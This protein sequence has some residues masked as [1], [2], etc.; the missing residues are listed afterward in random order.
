MELL[1]ELYSALQSLL[2]NTQVAMDT[3]IDQIYAELV[4]HTKDTVV[5]LSIR[6][7][8][9]WLKKRW[10]YHGETIVMCREHL[11]GRVGVRHP[12]DLPGCMRHTEYA[13]EA[14]E[15]VSDADRVINGYRRM[16]AYNAAVTNK[17]HVMCLW[18]S[19]TSGERARDELVLLWR[20]QVFNST[21]IADDGTLS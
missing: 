3:P 19:L 14:I 12:F 6:D 11:L 5:I 21:A 9:S 18:D 10:G 1:T 20:S 2:T 7:P 13:T 17:L 15:H 16:N 4:P 8:T